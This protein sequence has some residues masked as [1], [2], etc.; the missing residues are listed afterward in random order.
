MTRRNPAESQTEARLGF[1]VILFIFRSVSIFDENLLRVP[2]NKR[3]LPPQISVFRRKN[4]RRKTRKSPQRP[5]RR[6]MPPGPGVLPRRRAAAV[7]CIR[8]AAVGLMQPARH[9][10]S[11]IFFLM[12]IFDVNVWLGHNTIWPAGAARPSLCGLVRTFP[13]GYPSALAVGRF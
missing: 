3:T 13:N 2:R 6:F 12:C 1:C 4:L 8:R 11:H 7:W 9:A 5:M 10:S